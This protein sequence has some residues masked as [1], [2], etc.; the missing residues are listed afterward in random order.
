MSIR[1]P[2]PPHPTLRSTQRNRDGGA[3][4]LRRLLK[5]YASC[6]LTAEQLCT[7]C[8]ACVEAGVPGGNFNLYSLE[9]GKQSGRYQRHLDSGRPPKHPTGADP[10][11]PRLLG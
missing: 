10:I 9:E 2:P 5:L 11:A 1:P 6:R 3:D 4:L 7:M 8:H